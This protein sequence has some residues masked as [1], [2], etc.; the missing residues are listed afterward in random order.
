MPIIRYQ[1]G[2]LIHE[3]QSELSK[4]MERGFGS[5]ERDPSTVETSQWV[6]AVDIQE[7]DDHFLIEADVPGVL[8]ED[9]KIHMENNTLTIEGERE[10]ESEEKK[11]GYVRVERSYGKFYRRF[12]LP[13]SADAT[14]VSAEGFEGVIKITIPKVKRRVAQRIEVKRRK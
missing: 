6:P 14:Q 3:I 5:S 8:L 10:N 11:E 4:L 1:P 13:E 2:T 7:K 9:I 12:E